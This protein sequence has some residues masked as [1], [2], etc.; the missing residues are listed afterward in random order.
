MTLAERLATFAAALEFD[1]LPA[2][3]VASTRL[4]VLDIVGLALAASTY[5]FA[6]AVVAAGSEGG[7]CTVIG[8]P[9]TASAAGAPLVDGTLAHGLDLVDTPRLSLTHRP[10]VVVP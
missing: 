5:D 7:P 2:D 9:R 3:V 10:P 6:R 1:Q 8:A 4:R